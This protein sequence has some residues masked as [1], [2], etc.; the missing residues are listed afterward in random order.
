[1]LL[2]QLII[3]I[4]WLIGLFYMIIFLYDLY[5]IKKITKKLYW[6]SKNYNLAQLKKD[7]DNNIEIQKEFLNLFE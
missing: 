5:L 4:L 6:N 2:L 7:L 1:M 3:V